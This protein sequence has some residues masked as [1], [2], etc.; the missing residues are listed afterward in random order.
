VSST[1]HTFAI[2]GGGL[3][4]ALVAIQLLRQAEPGMRVILIER[5]PPA[6]RGVAYGTDCAAHLLN[7]PADRM[8][9]F[10]D[11]PGHFL[12]WAQARGPE[13]G[14]T[15]AITAADFLPRWLF[16]RYVTE[17]LHETAV[18]TRPGVS[19]ES[20]RGEAIDV[21]EG[22]A[23]ARIILA[24]G[25]EYRAQAVVLAIGNLP[26]EYPIL[27]P[28]R[29]YRG[30]RYVHVPWLPGLMSNIARDD[31]VLVVGAGLTA[32]DIIVQLDQL[33]HRGTVHALSRRGLH[34]LAH[35]SGP[36]EYPAFLAGEPLP[37]TVLS[38]LRRLRIELR[39]A[40]AEGINWRAVVDAIRPHSQAIWLGFSLAERKRF[41]RH[42]RPFW[43]VHRHRLAPETAATVERLAAAGRV[44]FIAGRLEA[45]HDELTCA[46]A[47][48]RVR[49]SGKM[50]KLC[51]AKVINCTGPRTD[52]SKY[53]HPLL[54][55][56]LARGLINHDPLALGINAL[57]S[58]EVLRYRAGPTGWLFTL[59]APLKGVL[60]ESTAV[61]EIRQHALA[62]AERLLALRLPGGAL[63]VR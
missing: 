59:G 44:R 32:I 20:V 8:G 25:R 63:T 9:L 1:P 29:F 11:D 38:L 18:A 46:E 15:G 40:A 30:P 21:E 49:G 50:H 45:L 58:G 23:D 28:L 55:N 3:G 37:A 22:P 19:L 48:Y 51:V 47:V 24:D 16:G 27:R 60:W 57:P 36:E 33:G 12:R 39:R 26:G 7:V 6:G 10:P 41:L 54:I 56:L 14:L 62:I 35:Y 61:P 17:T 31:D 4:G 42:A 13:L 52:Y 5:C 43:E 2:V 34:P 53:Q